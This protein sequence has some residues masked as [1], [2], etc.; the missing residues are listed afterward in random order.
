MRYLF[1]ATLVA[2]T[3]C[4]TEQ[5]EY[6]EMAILKGLLGN[7]IEIGSTPGRLSAG[8]IDCVALLRQPVKGEKQP[9]PEFPV[10]MVITLNPFT[11]GSA[12]NWDI[13]WGSEG[14]KNFINIPAADVGQFVIPIHGSYAKVRANTVG[15]SA[16]V[17]AHISLGYAPPP[18]IQADAETLAAGASSTFAL[19]AFTRRLKVI[20]SAGIPFSVGTAGFAAW[21]TNIGAGAE[22]EFT[23]LPSVSTVLNVRNDGV[24]ASSMILLVELGT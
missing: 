15:V 9:P 18:V 24:V 13:D 4:G 22:M 3:A 8:L 17:S 20:R 2:Q 1:L 21:E 10:E 16:L 12:V 5:E 19:P 23:E 7:T 6:E 11:Q 14:A